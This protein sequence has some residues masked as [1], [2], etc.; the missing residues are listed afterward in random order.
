M[1][2]R[3][4]VLGVATLCAGFDARAEGTRSQPLFVIA[5]SKNANVVHYE[6][7]VQRS[8]RLDRDEPVI[9]YW[10]MLAANG[11]REGLSWL[12]RKFAYGFK[13]SFEP[14]GDVL[15]VELTAFSRRAL[16]V[17]SDENGIFHA[18][19]AISGRRSRLERIFVAS[20]EGGITPSVRY[21]DLFGRLSDGARVSERILP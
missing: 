6:A 12:E 13:A 9:A 17:R 14:G 7:R 21:V 8:G 2:R 15:R 1:T 19:V 5:R 3:A 10:V 20:D 18:E 16:A 4:L 11:R